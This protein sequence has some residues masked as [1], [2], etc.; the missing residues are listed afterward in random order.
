MFIPVRNNNP[1]LIQCPIILILVP[2]NEPSLYQSFVAGSAF[3]QI[4]SDMAAIKMQTVFQKSH[5]VPTIGYPF[6][7]ESFILSDSVTDLSN[8]EMI[9]TI[10]V[11]WKIE[12][13][14]PKIT[15]VDPNG[16]VYPNFPGEEIQLLWSGR[17]YFLRLSNSRFVKGQWSY[18]IRG[19][20]DTST[21]DSVYVSVH[22]NVGQKVF[23]RTL[24]E[25]IGETAIDAQRNNIFGLIL[26][27]LVDHR[28]GIESSLN[29]S[30]YINHPSLESGTKISLKDDGLIGMCR[31]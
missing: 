16:H 28:Q 14:S 22:V 6:I 3:I 13:G 17:V 2:E 12:L 15:V 1:F 31:Q 11:P 27:T 23:G 9:M 19:I 26:M 8:P 20:E 18:S 30:A 25:S 5:N 24:V 21:E 4:S 7:N 29:V 10:V